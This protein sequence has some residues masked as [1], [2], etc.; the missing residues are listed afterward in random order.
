MKEITVKELALY[1]KEKDR[2][3]EM[4]HDQFEGKEIIFEIWEMLKAMRSEETVI[5]GSFQLCNFK[6][7][8]S[9]IFYILD[10]VR[11]LN[12]MREGY[13]YEFI[14]ELNDFIHFKILRDNIDF[15]IKYLPVNIKDALIFTIE[16]GFKSEV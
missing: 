4:S 6:Q 2:L 7:N 8:E 10:M 13:Y 9:E 14:H 1:L 11:F 5:C 3:Y 15:D 12:L 16:Q